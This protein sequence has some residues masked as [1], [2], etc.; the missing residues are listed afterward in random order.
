MM[1]RP[2]ILRSR[3]RRT[4]PP[5]GLSASDYLHLAEECLLLAALTED[6]EKVAELVKTADDYL[7]RSAEMIADQLKN[8]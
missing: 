4:A 8:D 5:K 1:H 6:P 2:P 3:R 7:R